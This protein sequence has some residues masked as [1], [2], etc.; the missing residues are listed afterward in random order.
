M[1]RSYVRLS[2]APVRFAAGASFVHYDELNDQVIT[3]RDDGQ[4]SVASF[5]PSGVPD[6]VPLSYLNKDGD[7]SSSRC[8]ADMRFLA[9]RRSVHVVEIIDLHTLETLQVSPKKKT[10]LILDFFWTS[11]DSNDIVLATSG[12][13]EFFKISKGPEQKAKLVKTVSTSK[14]VWVKWVADENVLVMGAGTQANMLHLFQF[15]PTEIVTYPKFEVDMPSKTSVLAP[16]QILA[17]RMYG[18]L[19]CLHADVASK[20]LIMYRVYKDLVARMGREIELFSKAVALS[21]VDNVV[22]V[23]NLDTK[24]SMIYDIKVTRF[25]FVNPLPLAPFTAKPR[26]RPLSVSL[27]STEMAQFINEG[28]NASDLHNPEGFELYK[29]DWRFIPPRTV[30]DIREGY[31][32]KLSLD[33]DEIAA[34]CIEPIPLLAFLMHR[35][36]AKRLVL[37]VLQSMLVFNYNL[38]TISAAFDLVNSAYVTSLKQRQKARESS[39]GRTTSVTFGNGEDSVDDKTGTFSII[40]QGDVYTHVFMSLFLDETPAMRVRL[41]EY[42]RAYIMSLHRHNVQTSPSLYELL[43]NSL[44]RCNC[45]HQ[46]DLCIRFNVIDDSMPVARLLLSLDKVY[47]PALSLGL[48]MLHRLRE[49]QEILK[50]LLDRSMILAACH[51][52]RKNRIISCPPKP[53]LEAAWNSQDLGLFF[54]VYSFFAQRNLV[55]RGSIDFLPKEDCEEYVKIYKSTFQ[56]PSA[57]DDLF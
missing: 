46:L 45:L 3:M 13:L 22:L 31:A 54:S 30:I 39:G 43:V 23:H 40:D 12:G 19:Y 37:S 26:P 47:P 2:E 17:S 53:F 9:I 35:S 8:S 57:D 50:V 20:R 32:W 24:V 33:L 34:A 56:K 25:P 5:N 15:A 7:V 49:H 21:A 10:T 52:V 48:D 51:F 42:I 27:S 11:M 14:V 28:S 18:I 38:S 41:L 4:F 29:S 44:H 55:V 36:N 1:D 16:K 6:E